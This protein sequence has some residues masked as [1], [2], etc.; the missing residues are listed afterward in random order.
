MY[1]AVGY[2]DMERVKIIMLGND[3]DIRSEAKKQEGEGLKK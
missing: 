2:N 1:K 3:S